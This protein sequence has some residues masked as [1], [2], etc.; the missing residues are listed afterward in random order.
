[1]TFTENYFI[2]TDD[3]NYKCIK[4]IKIGEF[5]MTISTE[6]DVKKYKIPC[7][8]TCLGAST[9]SFLGSGM[10]L[11][12]GVFLGPIIGSCIGS[13]IGSYMGFHLVSK[14]NSCPLSE[15]ETTIKSELINFFELCSISYINLSREM[16]KQI[17]SIVTSLI[18]IKNNKTIKDVTID[19]IIRL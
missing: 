1:M 5:V 9:G 6:N 4:D 16:K 14:I 17:F 11:L 3:G 10:G 8:G 15:I 19:E 7:L 18:V 12:S 13:Y 2:E